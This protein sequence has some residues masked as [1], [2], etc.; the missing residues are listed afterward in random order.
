MNFKPCAIVEAL[1]CCGCADSLVHKLRGRAGGAVKNE[2]IV[3]R[4]AALMRRK[5][6]ISDDSSLDKNALVGFERRKLRGRRNNDGRRER[7]QEYEREEAEQR[8]E[9]STAV[10]EKE[11]RKGLN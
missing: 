5:G 8:N 9:K 7:E 2:A 11:K 6:A 10:H 1:N 4:K 3:K